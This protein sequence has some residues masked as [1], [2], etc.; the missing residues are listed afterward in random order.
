[1]LLFF[2]Y[3]SNIE[4]YRLLNFNF[5]VYNIGLLSFYINLA[6]LYF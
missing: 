4:I 1:M 2:L 3:D 6:T 5:T